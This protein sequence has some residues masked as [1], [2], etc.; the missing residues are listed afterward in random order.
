MREVLLSFKTI[1][2]ALPLLVATG[3]AIMV[4]VSPA[5]GS[6]PLGV[7]FVWFLCAIIYRW[8]NKNKGVIEKRMQSKLAVSSFVINANTV[9]ITIEVKSEDIHG[10]GLIEKGERTV[11]MDTSADAGMEYE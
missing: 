4:A 3:A 6:I 7:A 8:I 1:R 9:N 10:R 5:I 2:I 11:I